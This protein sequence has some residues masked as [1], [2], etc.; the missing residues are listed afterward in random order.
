M[1]PRVL[2]V[3]PT[4]Y[5]AT[6]WG[7][8]IH[9]VYSLCNALK[10]SGLIDLRVLTTDS[11]GPARTDQLPVNTND[12]ATSAEGY[13]IYYS[14][15][16]AGVSVSPQL[17][18]RLVRGVAWA[19][20]IHLT[21]VYSFP[22]IPTLALARI[23]GKPLV[24]SPRGALQRWSGSRRPRLKA[25]WEWLCNLVVDAGQ[26]VLHATC[27]TE[28]RESLERIHCNRAEIIPN[29]VEIPATLPDRVWR[30]G[31]I[32]RLMYIGRL[33]PKKGLEN[34]IEAISRLG[35]KVALDVYGAGAE[36]Y[37][38]SLE[39][40]VERWCV[41]RRI[42]F[43]GHVEGQEKAAAFHNADLCIVPSYTENFA[44]V[45]AEALA[46][47][48]PV[49]ASTGTPW[50]G[51]MEQGCGNWVV[52]APDSL[53]AAIRELEGADLEAMGRRGRAWMQRDYSWETIARRMESVY[54]SLLAGTH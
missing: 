30:P 18:G 49:V 33:D 38:R 16:L 25:L 2:Y 39:Q 46:H 5:P 13:E 32:T 4:F 44:M 40:Q 29:G 36:V 17:L 37:V 53:A 8:P 35:D 7:G 28:A 14:R 15:R 11:A 52:N 43:R 24:W 26:C 31:G 23:K 50:Q 20:I 48:V 10:R 9:T 51:L 1:R 21:S 47:G 45:V 22:T 3:V 27:E 41:S 42:R 12:A 19:D 34:L 54:R 6:H